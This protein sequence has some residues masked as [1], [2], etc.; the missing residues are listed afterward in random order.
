MAWLRRIALVLA[1]AIGLPAAAD[2]RD[3]V[4]VTLVRGGLI[5]SVAQDGG[6]VA[7]GDVSR[8]NG[9][10]LQR[11]RN[12]VTI[13]DA[14][15]LSLQHGMALAGDR[16]LWLD[17][18]QSNTQ[19]HVTLWSGGVGRKQVLLKRWDT[20]EGMESEV[21][22]EPVPL[23]GDGRTL[24]HAASGG[25]T[26]VPG[27]P[28]PGTAGTVALAAR[29][30][31]FAAGRATDGGW[32]QLLAAAA[33]RRLV[34]V[35]YPSTATNA[36]AQSYIVT[37]SGRA[38]RL[39]MRGGGRAVA[40]AWSPDGKQLALV[41]A[42]RAV[43]VREG[44]AARVVARLPTDAVAVVGWSPD[45]RFLAVE[46]AE[47][48]RIVPVDGGSAHTV[49]GWGAAWSP[50]GK[51][52]AVRSKPG[53]VVAGADGSSPRMVAK[54]VQAFVWGDATT[55]FAVRDD[56]VV[57]LHTSGGAAR[58]AGNLPTAAATAFSS[59]GST[60]AYLAP[61]SVG[62]INLRTGA[63]SELASDLGKHQGYCSG[64]GNYSIE[65]WWSDDARHVATRGER[66]TL[67]V[68]VSTGK[69]VELAGFEPAQWLRGE[70]VLLGTIDGD[71]VA[72]DAEGG[73]ARQVTH[74]APPARN[75]VEI[76]RTSDGRL[77]RRIVAPARV[78]SVA[79]EAREVAVLVDAGLGRYT[80]ELYSRAGRHERSFALPASSENISM[81]G[82][83]VVFTHKNDIELLDARSG[84]VR[85]LFHSKW[86]PIN[87]TIEGHRVVWAENDPSRVRALTVP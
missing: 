38:Q 63:T 52:L 22:F 44:V 78:R 10:R 50:D 6:G 29:G 76:R 58:I 30:D 68:S 39:T 48:T 67:V 24:V 57:A 84:A 2:S 33:D 66:G 85:V 19:F 45:G 4:P 41:G 73:G 14:H 46:N 75:S 42:N 18:W 71:L 3:P 59:D 54:N 37:P 1:A 43:E 9:V 32:L 25:V 23:A 62:T 17:V 82:R 49:A 60:A 70:P 61:D 34:V 20:G 13:G 72:F 74:L 64:C 69:S 47:T 55:L 86:Q 28:V 56:S 51:R 27:G 5:E 21:G 53:L 77:L 26:R 81:S 65:S 11:G 35:R 40:A 31:A 87:P 8:A 83:L 80:L 12:V 16:A 79:L 36:H 7:W 15:N